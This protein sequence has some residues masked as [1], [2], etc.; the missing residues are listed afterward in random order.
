MLF[1]LNCADVIVDSETDD[2][3]QSNDADVE[4]DDD[5][6]AGALQGSES[7]GFRSLPEL[8]GFEV[9]CSAGMYG[10]CNWGE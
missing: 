1:P 6:N 2:T 3:S 5:S 4:A 9:C 7:G 8:V 10:N